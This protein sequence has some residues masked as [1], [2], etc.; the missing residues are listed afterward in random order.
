MAGLIWFVQLV[1][2]PQF[3][4]VGVEQFQVYHRRHTR[5]TTLAVGPPMLIE[6]ATAVALLFFRPASF[7][8]WAAAVGAALVLFLW[9]STAFI[10]VPRHNL[11]AGGFDAQVSK[12]LCTTNWLRTAGWTARLLL[13]AWFVLQAVGNGM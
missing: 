11:L 6:A 4:G 12:S 10:Q 1:H 2:Y 3:A 9:L 13:M 7:P 8:L 5:F